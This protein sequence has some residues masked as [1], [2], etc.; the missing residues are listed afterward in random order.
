MGA[1]VRKEREFHCIEKDDIPMAL[2]SFIPGCRHVPG[3][4]W[5]STGKTENRLAKAFSEIK[6]NIH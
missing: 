5:P 3:P 1:P 4:K 6:N 2:G